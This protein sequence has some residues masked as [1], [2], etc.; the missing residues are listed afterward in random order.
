MKENPV[1]RVCEHITSREVEGE[2]FIMDLRSLHTYALNTTAAFIWLQIDGFRTSEDIFRAVMER[3]DIAPDI[4]RG[5]VSELL[6]LLETEG[7]ISTVLK[8]G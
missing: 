1:Y 7:L 3:Y 2:A 5:E 6:S 4:C 8:N